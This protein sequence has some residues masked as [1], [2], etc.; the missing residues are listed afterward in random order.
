EHAHACVNAFGS[1]E[2]PCRNHRKECEAPR[3][4]PA[5]RCTAVHVMTHCSPQ[6]PPSTIDAQ[7]H[8]VEPAPYHKRPCRAMP[9]A[10]EKHC[11]QYVDVLSRAPFTIS[12]QRNV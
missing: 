4:G 1:E 8:A 5:E 9:E 6:G 2:D 10:G 12:A 7:E 11:N 3:H